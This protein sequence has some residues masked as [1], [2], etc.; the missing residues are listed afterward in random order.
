M[1]QP[2]SLYLP[3]VERFL[4]GGAG[5]PHPVAG[6]D[7]PVPVNEIAEKE[8]QPML[9]GQPQVTAGQKHAEE[10]NKNMSTSVVM[11]KICITPSCRHI[12]TKSPS[13]R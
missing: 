13:M 3:A 9:P 8:V 11:L 7:G 12:K 1:I 4:E 2:D 10:T 6:T 5:D